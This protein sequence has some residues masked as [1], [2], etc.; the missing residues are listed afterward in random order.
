[1]CVYACVCVRVCVRV[2]VCM[3]VRACVILW[4]HQLRISQTVG[5]GSRRSA[6]SISR[7]VYAI[8][9]STHGSKFHG[10]YKYHT[11]ILLAI[12]NV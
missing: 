12:R 9:K 6:V 5:S 3:C 10:R 11:V 1:M 2:C 4:R 8:L 7:N